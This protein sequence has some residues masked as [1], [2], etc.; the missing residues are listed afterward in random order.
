MRHRITL[1]VFGVHPLVSTGAE[2]VPLYSLAIHVYT[3]FM[4]L[5]IHVV[6]TLS[7]KPFVF[8]LLMFRMEVNYQN[9][10]KYFLSF[11]V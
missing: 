1:G 6:I 3:F 10:Y 5:P 7:F 11:A 8:E 4:D 2:H 9:T